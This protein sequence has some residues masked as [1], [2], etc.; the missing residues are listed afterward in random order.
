MDLLNEISLKSNQSVFIS[1]IRYKIVRVDDFT[2][3]DV[4]L[5]LH[6][7]VFCGEEICQDDVV[8]LEVF[9]R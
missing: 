7:L 2:G 1:I 3:G 4:D 9:G 6:E 5:S 8:V